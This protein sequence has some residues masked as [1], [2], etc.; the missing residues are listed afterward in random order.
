MKNVRKKTTKCSL[1]TA[2]DL[3]DTDGHLPKFDIYQS[4]VAQ[5][6]FKSHKNSWCSDFFQKKKKKKKKLS[7]VKFEIHLAR[8]KIV[9]TGQSVQALKRIIFSLEFQVHSLQFCFGN[10]THIIF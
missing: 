10:F 9:S 4:T 7:D 5:N 6:C 2:E 1:K 3:L 8:R